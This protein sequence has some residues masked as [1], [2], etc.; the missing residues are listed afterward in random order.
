MH[1]AHERYNNACLVIFSFQFSTKYRLGFFCN[2]RLN[3]VIA[4]LL[5]HIM[6]NR[7]VGLSR[8]HDGSPDHEVVVW[9]RRC[10]KSPIL[11]LHTRLQMSHVKPWSGGG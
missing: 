8:R 9:V 3:C 2:I 5:S 11:D 6:S 10:E 4:F 7:L 1:V